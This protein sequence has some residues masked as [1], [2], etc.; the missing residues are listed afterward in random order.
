LSHF[1][2]DYRAKRD[3]PERPLI[4]RLTLN[5][6]KLRFATVSGESIEIVS[7]LPKDFR[8]TRDQLA[9]HGR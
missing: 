9:R 8:A 2:R 6:E 5:A 3:R 1:K 7:P 4:E